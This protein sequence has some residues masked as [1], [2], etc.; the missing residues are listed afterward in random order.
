M[1]EN[2]IVQADTAGNRI[3]KA[4][5]SMQEK[6]SRTQIQNFVEEGHLLVNGDK[7]KKHIK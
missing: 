1:T 5:A 2:F 4:I 6:W 7:V 3:D